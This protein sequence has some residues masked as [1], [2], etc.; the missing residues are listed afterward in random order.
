MELRK[1]ANLFFIN[2]STFL[3][4]TSCNNGNI[5]GRT[6]VNHLISL[7]FITSTGENLLNSTA[8][9]EDESYTYMGG[10]YCDDRISIL[11]TRGSDGKTA[12]FSDKDNATNSSENFKIS[13]PYLSIP[14]DMSGY[15]LTPEDL[16]KNYLNVELYIN[17]K[18]GPTIK[19]II[20]DYDSQFSN[21]NYDE[22]Y[23]IRIISEAIY[24][25]N[26]PHYLHLAVKVKGNMPKIT[27][28][29]YDDT[30]T[31]LM[32]KDPFKNISHQLGYTPEYENTRS[33]AVIPIIVDRN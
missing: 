29:K 15:T 20:E 23:H 28:I 27:S 25:D 18:I 32:D 8:L 30:D 1:I 7:N 3:I 12:T 21:K 31:N 19:L 11:C 24:G 16:K 10:H 14:S 17:W 33:E 2:I 4:C 13:Y 6:F 26:E 22:N 9:V 5:N